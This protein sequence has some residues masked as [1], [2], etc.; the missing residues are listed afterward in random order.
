M[1]AAGC[2]VAIFIHYRA[3]GADLTTAIA[4]LAS[5][6]ISDSFRNVLGGAFADFPLTWF[7]VF[8]LV[9][10]TMAALHS[11]TVRK[12]CSTALM[13]LRVLAL[14]LAALGFLSLA[15]SRF[16]ADGLKDFITMVS[17]LIIGYG[18]GAAKADWKEAKRAFIGAA[19][20]S[21]IVTIV[22][23]GLFFLLGLETG[24]LRIYADR[25]AIGGLFSD[26]SFLS[27]FMACGAAALIPYRG[28][29]SRTATIL[30]LGASA[31]TS[32]RTGPAAFFAAL[33]VSSLARTRNPSRR[34]K[35]LS[36]AALLG[37]AGWLV[38]SAVRPGAGILSDNGRFRTYR[39]GL[40]N[41]AAAP[42]LGT[43][44][45]YRN[46]IES[47]HT[48]AEFPHNAYL[49]A[50]AQMGIPTGMALIL[51]LGGT[52]AAIGIKDNWSFAA[53]ACALAGALFIPDIM[54]SRFLGIL[55]AIGVGRAI[56]SERQEG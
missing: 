32:A 9:W 19:I 4:C 51:L 52:I 47:P 14:F 20:V 11:C 18:L 10:A 30:L 53:L 55:I 5:W 23:A 26:F 49:Q 28:F 3:R 16:V 35:A 43:G 39:S 27:L 12:S 36:A 33:V 54:N 13:R 15:N 45:G 25:T 31:L 46:Y 44:P 38:L 7:Y 1:L 17:C 56:E 50:I 41:I 6:S 22:Q 21:A 37:L 48:Y 42:I 40:E 29:A 8:F 2:Y 34:L 24:N